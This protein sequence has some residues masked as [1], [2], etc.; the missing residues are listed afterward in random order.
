MSWSSSTDSSSLSVPFSSASSA[1]SSSSSSSTSL[2]SFPSPTIDGD[3]HVARTISTTMTSAALVDSTVPQTN[4]PALPSAASYA[5]SPPIATCTSNVDLRHLA[6][7]IAEDSEEATVSQLTKEQ[8]DSMARDRQIA[9][10]TYETELEEQRLCTQRDEEIAHALAREMELEEVQRVEKAKAIERRDEAMARELM[11]AFE[12]EE[13]KRRESLEIEDFQVA[14]DLQMSENVLQMNCRFCTAVTLKPP[15]S[16]ALAVTC[17]KK[18]CKEKG[19]LCCDKMLPCKHP[20]SGVHQEAQ[21]NFCAQCAPE[22]DK[23]PICWDDYQESPCIRLECGHVM[24]YGCLISQIESVDWRGG[25]I[26]FAALQCA[27]GCGQ[28]ISHPLLVPKLAPLMDIR[29]KMEANA[30]QRAKQDKISTAKN[31]RPLSEV[32]AKYHYYLCYKCTTPYC[33]GRADLV[34]CREAQAEPPDPKEVVCPG[35]TSAGCSTC[36]VHGTGFVGFKCYYC[37]NT[38]TFFCWGKRHFCD[39]CH[40]IA[41]SV[42]PTPCKGPATC[43]LKGQHPPNPAEFALGCALCS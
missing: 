16:A 27:A 1:S 40:Q 19:M 20:C 18:E 42:K 39:P 7:I 2:S 31:P 43:P 12:E 32:L 17:D 24:H 37:C 38:A 10:Q 5:P 35:C 26:S 15:S 28:V 33:G 29:K 36:P 9:L 30:L 22:D 4:C 8:K 23:C 11:R 3:T 25:E 6:T 34:A 14:K 41:G 21:C 13:R